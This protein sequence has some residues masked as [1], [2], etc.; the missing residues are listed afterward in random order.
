MKTYIEIKL[1]KTATSISV[2]YPWEEKFK[3]NRI[4][5]KLETS[6]F[7]LNPESWEK[8]KGNYFQVSSNIAVLENIKIDTEYVKELEL[9]QVGKLFLWIQYS[10]ESPCL[11]RRR[12]TKNSEIYNL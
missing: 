5:E 2:L 11:W 8:K 6:N 7:V 10:E 3:I 9:E 1:R 12:W 4:H